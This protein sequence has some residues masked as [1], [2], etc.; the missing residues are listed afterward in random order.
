MLLGFKKQAQKGSAAGKI[1]EFCFL[2]SDPHVFLLKIIAS[3]I[4]IVF[5]FYFALIHG[6]LATLAAEAR[7][8]VVSASSR[9]K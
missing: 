2:S 5:M 7:D 3:N 1:L 9:Q 8:R 4:L 6:K